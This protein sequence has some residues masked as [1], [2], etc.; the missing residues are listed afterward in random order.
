MTSGRLRRACFRYGVIVDGICADIDVQVDSSGLPLFRNVCGQVNQVSAVRQ[1][2]PRWRL[3]E[4]SLTSIEMIRE[5]DAQIRVRMR[6]DSH[7]GLSIDVSLVL[8]AVPVVAAIDDFHIYTLSV[9][10]GD[11]CSVHSHVAQDGANGGVSRRQ[12]IALWYPGSNRDLRYYDQ[13]VLH[14][15]VPYTSLGRIVRC[16]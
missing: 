9:P 15:V 14:G 1:P 2:L 12:T 10:F 3:V 16:F 4:C 7:T 11:V 13:R 5:A 8:I 6:G